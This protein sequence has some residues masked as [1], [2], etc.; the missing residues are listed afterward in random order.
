MYLDILAK[1]S[2]Y[3]HKQRTVRLAELGAIEP[4]THIYALIDKHMIIISSIYFKFK[5]E[6]RYGKLRAYMVLDFLSVVDLSWQNYAVHSQKFYLL[7]SVLGAE[8]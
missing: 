3:I 5:R 1:V 2:Q 7:I 6:T 8:A 4:W